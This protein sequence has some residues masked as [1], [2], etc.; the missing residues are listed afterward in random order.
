MIIKTGFRLLMLF[1]VICQCS[2]VRAQSKSPSEQMAITVMGKWNDSSLINAGR[3]VKWSYEQGVLL[4]GI[5]ALWNRTADARYFNHIQKFID[6]YIG[7]DGTIRTYKG[8]DFNIDNVKTGRSLLT[9]YKVTGKQKYLKAITTLREQLRRQPR[10]SD[11]GFWH[12]KIYPN[13]MWLDGLYMG[14]PFYA[15]CVD[16]FHEDTAFN[17][18]ARQFILM[19]KHARDKKTGLLYHGWDDSKQQRWAN[20]TTGVSPNF[21]GRAMG[22]Y[23]MALVDVLDYFP[24]THP[25]WDSLIAILNRQA[26]AIK[27]FQDAKSGLWYQ[28]LDK[29]DAKGNYLE[30][31]A[32]CMFVYTLAKALSKGYIPEKYMDVAQ[33]GYQGILKKFIETDAYGKTNLTGTVSVAGLGGNPYRDGSYEYYISEKVVTNDQKG[34]GA[35]LLASNQMEL[36]ALP[37]PGKGKTVTLDYFFN[38]E[39]I[40]GPSGMAEPFHYKWEERDNNGS[41]FL[42]QAFMNYGAKIDHLSTA[43]DAN[44]LKGTNIYIIV[45]PDTKKERD[46]PNFIQPNDVS[47]ITDWVKQGGVL[48]LM[49][50]DSGNAEFEHFNQLAGSFGIHFN[51]DSKNRVVGADFPTGKI[52]VPAQHPIFKTARQIYIKELAS[53]SIKNPAVATL[54]D[55]GYVVM[56]VSKL[57]KGT[58]FAVGDPWL[59]NEYTDGRKLPAGY[60]NFKAAKDLAKWSIEQS[61]K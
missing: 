61:P 48:L 21:W 11:G 7:E 35:F 26:V 36:A 45:D 18:I 56:A 23:G 50:N 29:P 3:E 47:V 39:T 24:K 49:G 31:S 27:N 12:K 51:E 17:D 25:K 33:K 60:E 22:W 14:E 2:F 55:K 57:G 38:S 41:S 28:V 15:E 52:M 8:D 13:Q 5:E 58:V 43:P 20:K 34:V 42:A 46:N 30:A 37:K 10:T 53:L 32:S 16:L 54:Q 9:L 44:K 40:K 6:Y 1:F 59:Y 4:E 19:E